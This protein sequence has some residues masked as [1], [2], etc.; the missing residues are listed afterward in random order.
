MSKKTLDVTPHT[1][2]DKLKWAIVLALFVAGFW[3]NYQY[4]QIDWAL[5]LAGWIVLACIMLGVALQ[6]G[7]GKRAWI[8]SKEA[9]AELRKVFWPTRQETVQTTIMVVV[10]VI[11]TALLLWGIDSILLWLVT[12]LTGRG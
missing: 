8:F 3:A 11:I 6:T 2:F 10:M 4:A 9:R 5:R 7:F 12:W 1:G